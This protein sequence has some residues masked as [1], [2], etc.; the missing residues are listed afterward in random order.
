MNKFLDMLASVIVCICI[1]A[2]VVIAL[3]TLLF[4]GVPW[5]VIV[6]VPVIFWAI[7]RITPYE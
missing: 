7:V 5:W 2:V 4:N 3:G 1:L 6:A